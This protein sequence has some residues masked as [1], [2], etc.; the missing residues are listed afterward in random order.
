[1]GKLNHREFTE[2]TVEN[3]SMSAITTESSENHVENFDTNKDTISTFIKDTEY[4]VDRL[5]IPMPGFISPCRKYLKD[6]QKDSENTISINSYVGRGA[7]LDFKETLDNW[8]VEDEELRDAMIHLSEFCDTILNLI[9]EDKDLD[10]EIK[11]MKKKEYRQ[12]QRYWKD[13]SEYDDELDLAA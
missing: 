4:L 2:N 9:G 7:V 6:K 3:Q 1:M 10:K 12:Q 13:E 5:G 8:S 11:K